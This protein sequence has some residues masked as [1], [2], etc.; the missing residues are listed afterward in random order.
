M[1]ELPETITLGKQ[2]QKEVAGVKIQQVYPPSK[3]HKLCWFNGSPAGY[4]AL[5]QGSMIQSAEGFGIF[6]ELVLDNN[7][8]ICFSDGIN[9]RLV[10]PGSTPV[11]YQLLVEL[12]NKMALVFTVGMYGGISLHGVDYDNKYYGLSRASV[13]PLSD[14]FDSHFSKLFSASKPTLSAKAFMATE[15][16]LPGIGNGSLQDILFVA[17]IHPK[18]KIGTFSKADQDRLL[19]CIK[20][21][22]KQMTDLGGRDTETDLYGQPGGYKT[23]LSKNT[24]ATGCPT[25]HGEIIKEAYL[26]GSVYYCPNC[27]PL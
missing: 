1:L 26:G 2:L 23:L 24:L 20:S 10:K 16:R 19:I 21:V 7:K 25:C 3:I 18:R 17:G 27:Q 6:V 4:N 9:V 22:L 5:M 14:Q 13:S 8:R 15:Q 12:E 11:N